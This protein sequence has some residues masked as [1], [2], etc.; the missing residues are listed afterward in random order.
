MIIPLLTCHLNALQT[1]SLNTL[2]KRL[3]QQLPILVELVVEAVGDL[4]GE[5]FGGGG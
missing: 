2:L 4:D 5:F 3:R 1:I